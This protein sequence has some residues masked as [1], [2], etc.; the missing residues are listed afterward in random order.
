MNEKDGLPV[1]WKWFNHL[2]IHNKKYIPDELKKENYPYCLNN[3]LIK[4]EHKELQQFKSNSS[5][6]SIT[7]EVSTHAEN[8]YNND[9]I[10]DEYFAMDGINK[11]VGLTKEI[12][13]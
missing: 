10:F 8:C 4:K 7:Q 2:P 13:P 5:A 6:S 11:N 1:Q 9:T 3:P 12:K